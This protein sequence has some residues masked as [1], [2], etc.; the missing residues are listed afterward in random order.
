MPLTPFCHALTHTTPCT[1]AR[2]CMRA[3]HTFCTPEH[4]LG[5]RHVLL[6]C[7]HMLIHALLPLSTA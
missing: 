6:D 1:P 5:T 7:M 3:L 2:Q 4:Q